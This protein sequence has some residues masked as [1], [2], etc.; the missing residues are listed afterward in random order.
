MKWDNF[1]IPFLVGG[2][3]RSFASFLLLPLNV[4]RVRLHMKTYTDEEMKAKNLKP[5]ENAK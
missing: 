2:F 3:C 4:V 5:L 1:L